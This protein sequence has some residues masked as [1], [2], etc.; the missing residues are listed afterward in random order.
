MKNILLKIG[1]K[2]LL[3]KEK[4]TKTMK[5]IHQLASYHHRTPMTMEPDGVIYS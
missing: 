4:K 3:R 5:K 2:N 1:L